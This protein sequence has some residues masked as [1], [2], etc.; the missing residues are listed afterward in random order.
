MPSAAAGTCPPDTAACLLLKCSFKRCSVNQNGFR[1]VAVKIGTETEETSADPVF[2]EVFQLLPVEKP[3]DSV[4][5]LC[6]PT[7]KIGRFLHFMSTGVY[8]LH[9]LSIIGIH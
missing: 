2:A 8:V 9:I 5:N 1:P 3:V 7:R 6:L 4:E